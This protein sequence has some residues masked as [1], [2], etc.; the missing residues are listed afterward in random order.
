MRGFEPPTSASRKQRSTKLSYIPCTSLVLSCKA[1][2]CG[3]PVNS[4]NSIT[5]NVTEW[6]ILRILCNKECTRNNAGI[7]K[8]PWGFYTI[9]RFNPLIASGCQPSLARQLLYPVFTENCWYT[10]L[11]VVLLKYILYGDAAAKFYYT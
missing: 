2:I 7:H 8:K 3:N 4:L 9:N 5:N 10:F 6:Q 11:T 1:V